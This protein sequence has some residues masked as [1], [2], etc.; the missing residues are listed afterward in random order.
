MDALIMQ[1]AEYERKKPPVPVLKESG[2]KQGISGE[3]YYKQSPNTAL[4]SA[5]Y[6]QNRL[7]DFRI[8]LFRQNNQIKKLK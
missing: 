1:N 6:N 3:F 7:S 4:K 2:T 8:F 5:S